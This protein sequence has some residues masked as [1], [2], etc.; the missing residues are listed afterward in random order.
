VET[1]RRAWLHVN[2]VRYLVPMSPTAMREAMRDH[3]AI[4][5]AIRD[6]STA[7]CQRTIREHLEEPLRRLLRAHAALFPSVFKPEDRGQVLQLRPL[8]SSQ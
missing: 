7:R 4:L 1:A 3:R 6:G 2:R 8:E 5:A